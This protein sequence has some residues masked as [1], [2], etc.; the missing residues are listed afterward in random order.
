MYSYFVVYYIVPVFEGY[1]TFQM[2]KLAYAKYIW[3]IMTDTVWSVV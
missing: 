2:G 3:N 1:K